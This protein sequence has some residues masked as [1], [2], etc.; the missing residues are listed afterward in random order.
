V[1]VTGKIKLARTVN[2]FTL[3]SAECLVSEP[4]SSACTGDSAEASN[5]THV[6][7]RGRIC[8]FGVRNQARLEALKTL[9]NALSINILR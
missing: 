9:K 5:G 7:A 3:L 2:G 6:Q 4:N 1:I 8:L